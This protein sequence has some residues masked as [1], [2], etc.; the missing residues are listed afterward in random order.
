MHA[1]GTDMH[2]IVIVRTFDVN[3]CCLSNACMWNRHVS[4]CHC[5]KL[6]MSTLVWESAWCFSLAYTL[7]ESGQGKSNKM[8]LIVWFN[9][10]QN[11]I[12]VIPHLISI[13]P[14]AHE[15]SEKTWILFDFKK[16]SQFL[17]ITFDILYFVGKL[18]WDPLERLLH[19]RTWVNILWGSGFSW[20]ARR[21]HASGIWRRARGWNWKYKFEVSRRRRVK[22]LKFRIGLNEMAAN[23]M[24]VGS[25]DEPGVEIYI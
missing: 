6:L 22:G 5:E 24:Q 19:I 23:D 3:L 8:T 2:V 12:Q 13:V 16:V 7:K 11:F 18:P 25:G 20:V 17:E 4:H 21:R 10:I 1:Y 9:F 15:L 14:T